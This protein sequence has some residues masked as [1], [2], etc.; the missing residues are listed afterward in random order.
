MSSSPGARFVAEFAVLGIDLHMDDKV[1]LAIAMDRHFRR[2]SALRRRRGW[3]LDGGGGLDGRE[4]HGGD[5]DGDS[6]YGRYYR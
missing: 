2:T 4:D 6:Y 3:D 1:S 5:G